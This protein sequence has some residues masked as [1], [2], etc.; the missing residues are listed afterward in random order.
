MRKLLQMIITTIILFS[1]TA[2]SKDITITTSNIDINLGKQK[3]DSIDI[4][5]VTYDFYDNGYAFI[6]NILHENAQISETVSYEGN[7]YKVVAIGYLEDD[8]TDRTV[9]VFNGEYSGIKSPQYLKLPNTIEYIS[10]N[11]LQFSTAETITLP[12]NITE[13]SGGTFYGC[14]NIETIDFPDSINWIGG[15][16]LFGRC[17]N[18]KTVKFPTNCEVVGVESCFMECSSLESVSI[19][20]TVNR[21]GNM[22]FYNCY[23]LSDVILEEGIETIGTWT[24]VTCPKLTHLVI[25]ESVTL[26]EEQAF[27]DC[28]NLI[29]LTLPDNMTDVSSNLFT[30]IYSQPADVSK[31]TIRVK[32]DLVSYVQSIYPDANVVAK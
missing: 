31:M 8:K 20:G 25:P 11:A 3:Y 17:T 10:S 2:C 21:T 13:I 9:G 7:E 15:Y 32:E 18:L 19:P 24:F 30:D 12:E 14:S 28:S 4:M 27:H 16:S 1:L 5:G 22:T 23:E 29:D 6:K 26:I